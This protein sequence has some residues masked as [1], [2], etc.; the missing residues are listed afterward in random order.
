MKRSI[1]T[2]VVIV[3]LSIFMYELRC[4]KQQEN[5][6]KLKYETRVAELKYETNK[7]K[8]YLI[9]SLTERGNCE[10]VITYIKKN[11]KENQTNE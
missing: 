8:L 2:I 4:L 5:A 9:F 7:S 11:F 6:A 1:L 10:Q 3:I